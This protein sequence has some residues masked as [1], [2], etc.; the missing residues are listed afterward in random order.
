MNLIQVQAKDFLSRN[1]Q[2]GDHYSSFIQSVRSELFEYRKPAHR[3]E[4][5]DHLMVMLKRKYDKHLEHCDY[6]ND[7]G[8]C[9]KNTQYENILFFIQ[10]EKDD[11]VSTISSE[12]YTPTERAALNNNIQQVLADLQTLK[13][14]QQI[15]Y[16]D[17]MQM[18]E[19]LKELYFLG[20]KNWTQLLIGKLT[21]MV[22]SGVV[23]ETVSKA[24]IDV[25]NSRYDDFVQ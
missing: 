23:S 24:I 8:K 20:K 21:E 11:I 6:K 22:A 9:S 18:T 12:E 5:I 1:F 17:L 10:N 14:G 25:V 13:D 19:E 16:D 15:T 3:L 7:R 4:F 2:E